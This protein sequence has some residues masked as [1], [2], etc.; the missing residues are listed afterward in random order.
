MASSLALIDLWDVFK[1]GGQGGLSPPG[2]TGGTSISGELRHYPA[3]RAGG[4]SVRRPIFL[5][6]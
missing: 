4:S 3:A 6:G 5:T 2:L 1:I